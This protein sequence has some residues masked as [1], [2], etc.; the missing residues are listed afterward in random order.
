MKSLSLLVGLV[1]MGAVAQA[2]LGP[3]IR[4]GE[5]AYGGPGCPA[6]TASVTLS[7][8]EDAIS[9]LFDQFVVEA[10]GVTGKRV[11][12][13]SCNLSIPV[14]IP[15]GYSVA[16]IQTD[17]RGFNLVPGNGGM[18]RLDTEYFW[19]GI[20]GPRFSKAF[21]G[22][23]ADNYTESN[24]IIAETLV[25]TPC[26]ASI[27]MRVNSSIMT[28]SNQRMEQAM[29]TVDSADISSGLLYHLQWRQCW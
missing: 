14:Q 21:R 8:N 4:L 22:P 2:Q 16:V 23:Q 29:M 1:M 10:G 28:Q 7:P 9:I 6:G 26:G 17:Y 27:T 18:N 5:P 25:W 24:G 19:A 3:G 11:D 20:R 13:K 12:R 15:Q